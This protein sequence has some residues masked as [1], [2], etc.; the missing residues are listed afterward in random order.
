[1]E[2]DKIAKNLFFL[3]QVYKLSF[4]KQTHD[5]KAKRKQNKNP[6][7]FGILNDGNIYSPELTKLQ[8]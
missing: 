2:Y 4:N 1:M 7:L 8:F 3:P 5:K 6:Q